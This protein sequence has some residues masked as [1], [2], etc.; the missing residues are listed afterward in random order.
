MLENVLLP[1]ICVLLGLE[2]TRGTRPYELMSMMTTRATMTAG[3]PET[4]A[5]DK[6][7]ERF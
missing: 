1:Y 4:Q 5:L 6:T 2:E 3:R 7:L